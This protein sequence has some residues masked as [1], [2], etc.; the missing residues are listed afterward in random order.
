VR[1]AVIVGGGLA[2]LAAGWRLRDHDVVLL[3]SGDR[4]GGRIRSERRG[5]YYLNWGGHVFAGANS[6]TDTL[7]RETSVAAL[8]IPG[9]LTG[10]AMNGKLLLGGRVETYP[11]RIP[12]SWSSR[13]SLLKAG[14]KVGLTV[15]RYARIVGLRPE[16]T[17][18][19]DSSGSTTSSTTVLLPTTSATCLRTPRRSSDPLCRVPQLTPTRSRPAPGSVTSAWCGISDRG[20]A[21]TSPAAPPPSSRRSRPPSETRCSSAPA[22][23]RWSTRSPLSSSLLPGW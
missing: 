8:A 15:L 2:G 23:S 1:D 22:S 13:I 21:G 14:G 6:G 11:F 18:P 9:A 5:Q 3:E 16:R 12:M 19:S 4:I 7:L 20:S 10:L 17:K